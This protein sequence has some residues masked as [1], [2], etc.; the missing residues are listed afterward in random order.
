[1]I[2]LG[3]CMAPRDFECPLCGQK[4][5]RVSADC[6]PLEDTICASCLA[7]LEPDEP[8]RREQIARLIQSHSKVVPRK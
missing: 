2:S 4:F 6:I 7:E 3:I 8:A 1:M 5:T